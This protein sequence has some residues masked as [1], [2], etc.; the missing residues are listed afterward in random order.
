MNRA[1][2]SLT[3]LL[4]PFCLVACAGSKGAYPSLNKREVERVTGTA[5]PVAPDAQ[6]APPPQASV[7]LQDRLAGLL[8]RA[9]Q[10][11]ER[12]HAHEAGAR[13]AVSAAA[14]AA[15]A[16]EGWTRAQ[17]ALAELEAAR[18]DAVISLAEL[19]QLYAEERI[20]FPGPPTPIAETIAVTRNE[21]G[22]LVGQQ[23]EAIA[24]LRRLSG[25]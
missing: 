22:R 20:A 18:S 5:E 7:E 4:L 2:A 9:Q 1:T 16:S 25:V 11:N 13:S 21:V 15:V 3:A 6:P 17:V 24:A 8:G 12:F 14:N 23:D 19:D 10:A